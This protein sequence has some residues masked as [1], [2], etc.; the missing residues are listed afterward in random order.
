VTYS[1]VARDPDTGELAGQPLIG[2][3]GAHRCRGDGVL[4]S[5]G[6]G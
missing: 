2:D 4:L 1:I 5:I 3:E 6:T